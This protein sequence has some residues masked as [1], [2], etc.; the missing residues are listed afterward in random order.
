MNEYDMLFALLIRTES[1][2]GADISKKMGDGGFSKEIGELIKDKYP[3]IMVSPIA[4]EL[5]EDDHKIRVTNK[6]RF[7]DDYE[8]DEGEL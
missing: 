3:N 7:D 8:E 4:M 6:L 1:E 2:N 5:V